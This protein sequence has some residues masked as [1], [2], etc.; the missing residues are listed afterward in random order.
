MARHIRQTTE[1]K[2]QSWVKRN[3]G[4]IFGLSFAAAFFAIV[5]LALKYGKKGVKA[6]M[7]SRLRYYYF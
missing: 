6:P 5:A 1:N 4:L 7:G 2:E 3:K